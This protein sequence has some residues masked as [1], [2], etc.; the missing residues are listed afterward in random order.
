MMKNSLLM[1]GVFGEFRVVLFFST[2]KGY[3]NN[4]FGGITCSGSM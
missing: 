2:E 3:K 1:A 4:T